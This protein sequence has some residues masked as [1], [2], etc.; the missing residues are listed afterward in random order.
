M[1]GKK[2][3]SSLQTKSS[4]L[5]TTVFYIPGVDV[6]VKTLKSL[7]LDYSLQYLFS[8]MCVLPLLIILK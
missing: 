3:P 5:E 1:T 4:D 8:V 7:G 6:K 2:V